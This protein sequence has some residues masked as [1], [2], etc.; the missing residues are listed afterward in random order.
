MTNRS[1]QQKQVALRA[2]AYH[3]AGHAAAA[4]FL[5]LPFDRVDIVPDKDG[6]SLGKVE[7]GPVE[8]P[9]YPKDQAVL[10]KLEKQIIMT[11]AGIVAEAMH[12]GRLNW[13]AGSEDFSRALDL[14]LKRHAEG[15]LDEV[16][17]YLKYLWVRTYEFTRH[18]YHWTAIEALARAL[19]VDGEL[20]HDEAVQVMEEAIAPLVR[21]HGWPRSGV[22]KLK[23]YHNNGKTTNMDLVRYLM[24]RGLRGSNWVRPQ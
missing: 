20:N 3:E 24:R 11:F 22:E 23:P 2:T 19:T 1:S 6:N 7:Y 16:E 4:H 9:I 5:R 12:T 21:Q 10:D 13:R 17:A 14:A 15:S 18:R 8:F